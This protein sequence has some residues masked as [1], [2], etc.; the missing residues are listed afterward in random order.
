MYRPIKDIL[1]MSSNKVMRSYKFHQVDLDKLK[2]HSKKTGLA[3]T[4]II[5]HAL[6]KYFDDLASVNH[7]Q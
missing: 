4:R 6:A 2:A 3:Q 7:R 5:E 1:I